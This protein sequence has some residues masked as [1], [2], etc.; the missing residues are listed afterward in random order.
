M[1]SDILAATDMSIW[2][3][4]SLQLRRVR[5][6]A[7]G[8]LALLFCACFCWSARAVEK[9]K[10]IFDCDLAGDIDD[11]FAL[12]LVLASPELEVVGLVMDH[13]N[14]AGRARVACRLLYEVGRE[15]IPVTIGR[16]TPLIVGEQT[17]VAG[18]AAQFTWGQGFEKLKPL[19]QPGADFIIS[20]LR[21]FPHEIVL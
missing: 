15:T 5:Q 1:C 13:G 14:T 4:H 8:T 9:Q 2:D 12:S 6:L 10:I 11:A 7:L 16:S 3:Q 20:K 19:S 18:D 17:G 21:Q